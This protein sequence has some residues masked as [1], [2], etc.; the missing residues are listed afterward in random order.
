MMPLRKDRG[1]LYEIFIS[2]LQIS[3]LFFLPSHTISGLHSHLVFWL[4]VEAG[5]A[6]MALT[7]TALVLVVPLK[8]SAKPA[9]FV[10][11]KADA[12]KKGLLPWLV[13]PS[14]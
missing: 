1:N 9:S 10:G 2:G 3:M 12:L 5:L 6:G 7:H 8:R 14:G 11:E 4:P 13:W